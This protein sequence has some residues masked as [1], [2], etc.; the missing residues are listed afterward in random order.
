MRNC[1]LPPP[2]LQGRYAFVVFDS[3]RRSLLAARDASGAYPLFLHQSDAG[4]ALSSRPQ[5]IPHGEEEGEWQELP[6][7]HCMVG[8]RE[9][10]GPPLLLPA[11]AAAAPA[12]AAGC[13]WLLLAAAGCCWLLLAAGCCCCLSLLLLLLLL[14]LVLTV[15]SYAAAASPSC[16]SCC[17]CC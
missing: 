3:E 8:R 4:T 11:A 13:C 15:T 6:P 9:T 17:C 14:L 16:S 12:A 10:Q 5:S 2:T 1:H 7:G